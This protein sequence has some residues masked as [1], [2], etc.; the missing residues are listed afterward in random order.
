MTIKLFSSTPAL[1]RSVFSWT[2]SFILKFGNSYFC[3]GPHP[4][5]LLLPLLTPHPPAHHASPA[6]LLSCSSCSFSP[7]ANNY[8]LLFENSIHLSSGIT[9]RTGEIMTRLKLR[10]SRKSLSDCSS[11]LRPIKFKKIKFW[12]KI[13]APLI[14]NISTKN[15]LVQF[16]RLKEV[17]YTAEDVNR[18]EKL[19]KKKV[20]TAL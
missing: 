15:F 12:Q 20:K 17:G 19:K 13:F 16:C 9:L 4:P 2:K 5:P 7:S 14:D 10:G 8:L 18:W 3:T 6:L 11:R 1:P